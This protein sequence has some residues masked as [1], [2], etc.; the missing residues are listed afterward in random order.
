[1]KSNN[2]SHRANDRHVITAEMMDKTFLAE[3]MKMKGGQ[4]VQDC[5]QCGICAGSCFAS[6]A[7]DFTPMQIVRMLHLGMKDKVL[8]SST[9]WVCASCYNCA[10]RC[11]RGLDIPMIMSGLKNIAIREKIP[12]KIQIKPKFHKSFADIVQKYGRMHE[13]ELFLKISNKTSPKT[14]MQDAAFGLTLLRKGKLKLKA[15]KV[16]QKAQW[17]S[18]F[19]KASEE[20]S[21]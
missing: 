6:W 16:D 5:I 7:M 9:I 10:T 4:N 8:S 12:A 15:P 1:M 20:G 17:S 14:M 21:K 19:K 18:L 2:N 11:P 3:V 13:P